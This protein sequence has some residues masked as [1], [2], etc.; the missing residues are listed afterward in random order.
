MYQPTPSTFIRFSLLGTRMAVRFPWIPSTMVYT[1][2]IITSINT[3]TSTP[4]ARYLSCKGCI[5]IVYVCIYV[6]KVS[7]IASFT[8]YQLVKK[9][10]NFTT[11]VRWKS[12]YIVKLYKL[13]VVEDEVHSGHFGKDGAI[14]QGVSQCSQPWI[15]L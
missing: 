10:L 15:N 6:E 12:T 9:E 1:R 7:I 14:T 13:G 5:C 4:R 11:H 3:N 2:R 8:F